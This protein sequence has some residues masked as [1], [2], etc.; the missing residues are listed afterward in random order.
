MTTQATHTPGPWR[1]G[2]AGHTVFGP[3][4]DSPSPKIIASGLSR[5]DAKLIG[6]APT[7]LDALKAALPC[8]GVA[9]NE[10]AFARCA[11]PLVGEHA[12]AQVEAAIAAAEQGAG[13]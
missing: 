4:T 10:K 6:V 3:K 12:W 11:A 5:Q 13:Q 2:D 9:I 1:I 7:M 8:L